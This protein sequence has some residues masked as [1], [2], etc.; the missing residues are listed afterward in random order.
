MAEKSTAARRENIKVRRSSAVRRFLNY[1]VNYGKLYDCLAAK[2]E[3]L[4]LEH[5]GHA[6]EN[7][8]VTRKVQEKSQDDKTI[9]AAQGTV[10]RVGKIVSP[11]T[12]SAAETRFPYLGVEH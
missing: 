1:G 9:L 6:S 8:S 11:I 3:A 2:D 5:C 12:V 4:G 7:F 10:S